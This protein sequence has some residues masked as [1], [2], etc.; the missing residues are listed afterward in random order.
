MNRV[1]I[2]GGG[3]SGLAAAFTLE[4]QRRAGA[5]EYTLYESSRMVR[6]W[7]VPT[8]ILPNLF[9]PELPDKFCKN[10]EN[11]AGTGACT[12]VTTASRWASVS[13]T[14]REYISRPKPSPASSADFK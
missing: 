7:L 13:S 12:A 1:A 6:G 10:D 9:S 4:E 2:I 14:V 5:V 8:M 3:I 11:Y